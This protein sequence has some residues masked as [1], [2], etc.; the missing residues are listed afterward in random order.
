M[1][2]GGADSGAPPSRA[3][4]VHVFKPTTSDVLPNTQYEVTGMA[5]ALIRQVT[6]FHTASRSLNKMEVGDIRG[7]GWWV[8]WCV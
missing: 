3:H 7:A 4:E 1:N 2:G 8:R 6:N 5:R